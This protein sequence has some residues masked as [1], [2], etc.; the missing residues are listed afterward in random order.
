[1]NGYAETTIPGAG[2]NVAELLYLDWRVFLALLDQTSGLHHDDFLPA[3][4]RRTAVNNPAIPAP[5][6]RRSAKSS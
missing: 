3:R 6:T 5:I 2:V 4:A 1:M